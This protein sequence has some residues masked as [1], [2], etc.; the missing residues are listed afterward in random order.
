MKRK[1]RSTKDVKLLNT[2]KGVYE[3]AQFDAVLNQKPNLCNIQL[4]TS[5]KTLLTQLC[6]P[7]SKEVDSKH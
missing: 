6:S 1:L 4:T 7:E 3:E 2:V 5:L